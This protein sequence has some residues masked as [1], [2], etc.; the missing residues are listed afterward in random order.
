[1]VSPRGATVLPRGGQ[2]L[3]QQRGERGGAL[4]DGGPAVAARTSWAAS[5]AATRLGR[6]RRG[7]V[8]AGVGP[9][10]PSRPVGGVRRGSGRSAPMRRRGARATPGRPTASRCRSGRTATSG[11]SPRRSAAERADVDRRSRR[12]PARRRA[13]PGRRA[14]G[15]LGG[16]QRAGHPAHVRAGDELSSA[17]RPRR[18]ARRTARRARRRRAARAA[19]TSGPSRPGCSS[20]AVRTSSPGPEVQPGQDAHR[21]RRWCTCQRDV[22]RVGAEQAGVRRA[23]GGRAA[24]ISASKYAFAR[25]AA[26]LPARA[27]RAAALTAACGSGPQVP[28]FR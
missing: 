12:R 24:S 21:R 23:A 5:A 27:P 3:G 28:A 25:P 18:R 22:G 16:R 20:A 15:E 2:P 4:V 8:A 7:V 10:A 13:A 6:Q 9:G 1:M 17:G 14:S 26:A 11:P 19:S